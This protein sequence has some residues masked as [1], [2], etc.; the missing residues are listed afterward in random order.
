MRV[1][2]LYFRNRKILCIL[3]LEFVAGI[4]LACV[5]AAVDD[6]KC[7]H[8]DF[9]SGLSLN[10]CPEQP[11]QTHR[12]GQS[13]SLFLALHLVTIDLRTL[14]SSGLVVSTCPM[15]LYSVFMPRS[16][17]ASG[18]LFWSPGLRFHRL[19]PHNGPFDKAVVAQRA[20]SPPVSYRW[21][22]HDIRILFVDQ[23][24]AI[25]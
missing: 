23:H 12:G 4:L 25:I 21:C 7:L 22:V 17:S 18:G 3:T 1:Y 9:C 13:P 11:S 6:W 8:V 20:V 15:K 5:S 16:V 2:A 19:C 10:C 14:V 24:P